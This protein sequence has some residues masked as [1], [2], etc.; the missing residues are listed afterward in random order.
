MITHYTFLMVN[1]ATGSTA[2]WTK[3]VDI[4]DYPELMPASE[5]L[6]NTTLSLAARSY[7]PGIKGGSDAK[8]FTANYTVANVTRLQGLKGTQKQYAVWFGGT[9]PSAV[10]EA[11][12]PTGSDGKIEFEGTLDFGIVSKGINEVREIT[13]RIMP[14]SEEIITVS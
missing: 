10:G 6:E 3:V 1:E 11:A 12:T 4:K 7:E 9:A 14:A 8:E 5:A 2:N 13:V